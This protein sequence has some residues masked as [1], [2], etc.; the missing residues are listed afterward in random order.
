MESM[1][2][3]RRNR[4]PKG[5]KKGTKVGAE[6]WMERMTTE[7][8]NRDPKGRKKDMKIG[9]ETWMKRT[10]IE[11]RNQNLRTWKRKSIEGETGS[12]RVMIL[13]GDGTFLW[14][15]LKNTNRLLVL[16][17]PSSPNATFHTVSHPDIDM[18]HIELMANGLVLEHSDRK[19]T[20]KTL[21]AV[22]KVLGEP[23]IEFLVFVAGGIRRV[24][25]IIYGGVMAWQEVA[26]VRLFYLPLLFYKPVILL[27]EREGE[28][29]G[30][31]GG[32]LLLGMGQLGIPGDS[33]CRIFLSFRYTTRSSNSL[34]RPVR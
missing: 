14:L 17:L 15:L 13:S 7:R 8:R 12:G 4:D 5:R 2:T 24:R 27:R 21:Q 16:R 29:G 34:L 22:R 19:G 6:T 28:P 33:S 31:S 23:A 10:R 11:R 20:A 25:C 26:A 3:E 30:G 32:N 1:R 18:Q 9:A